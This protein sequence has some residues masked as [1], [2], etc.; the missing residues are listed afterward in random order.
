[1]AHRGSLAGI[2]KQNQSG[3]SEKR[4]AKKRIAS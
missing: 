1:M 4:M 2:V 3:A